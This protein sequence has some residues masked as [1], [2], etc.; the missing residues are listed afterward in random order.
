MFLT[1]LESRKFKVKETMPAKDI[2]D[3]S[4]NDWAEGLEKRR[5]NSL[6]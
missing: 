3:A 5:P 4:F 2:L 6:L 1:I